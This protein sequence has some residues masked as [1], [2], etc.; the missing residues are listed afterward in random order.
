MEMEQVTKMVMAYE[1]LT[2]EVPKSH[3]AKHLGIS[4]RT[5]IRWAQAIEKHGSLAETQSQREP[6]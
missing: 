4:R 6:I 5:V 3:I 2:Q 1:L